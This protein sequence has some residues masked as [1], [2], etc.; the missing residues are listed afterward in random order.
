MLLA[1]ASSLDPDQALQNN[2]PD[3]GSILFDIHVLLMQQSSTEL[4]RF[5]N[6]S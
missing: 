6:L 1:F 4:K 2:G 5:G 3:P